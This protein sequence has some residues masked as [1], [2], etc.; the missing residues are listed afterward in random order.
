MMGETGRWG[1]A[2]AAPRR[3][4]GLCWKQLPAG[5]FELILGVGLGG[6]P[7]AELLTPSPP[8]TVR[9][10]EWE[11][12]SPSCLP[13]PAGREARGEGKNSTAVLPGARLRGQGFPEQGGAPRLAGMRRLPLHRRLR[14]PAPS[15]AAPCRGIASPLYRPNPGLAV[16]SCR[17]PCQPFPR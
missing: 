5:W 17:G 3:E 16:T 13:Q 10:A 1:R 6:H 15:P 4:L 11:P 8:R 7:G 9:S 14:V 2:A 12:S